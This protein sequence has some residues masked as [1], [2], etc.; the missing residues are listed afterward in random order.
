MRRE[1]FPSDALKEPDIR[2]LNSARAL[3]YPRAVGLSAA[4]QW[5]DCAILV[6]FEPRRGLSDLP[7]DII[8]REM[9]VMLLHHSRVGVAEVRRH[10][11]ER[12]PGHD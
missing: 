10:D 9:A 7:G 12:S 8:G 2:P 3:P 11:K 4:P 5:N 1:V 6:K